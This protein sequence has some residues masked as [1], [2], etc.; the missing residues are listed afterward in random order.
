MR[1][2]FKFLYAL[3]V[4]L[5][6]SF[7][8]STHA[9]TVRSGDLLEAMNV[10]ADT[11]RYIQ[12]TNTIARDPDGQVISENTVSIGNGQYKIFTGYPFVRNGADWYETE[13]ATTTKRLYDD[14][15]RMTTPEQ[16]W[17]LDLWPTVSVALA[18]TF[19]PS[20]DGVVSKGGAAA[21]WNTVRQDTGTNAYP[22]I[23]SGT[24][25]YI[26]STGGNYTHI[27]RGIVCFDGST[28]NDTDIVSSG[29]LNFSTDDALHGGTPVAG[30]TI[31]EYT[32]DSAAL[33]TDDY[34]YAS[35]GT[36]SASDDVI[37]TTDP[38]HSPTVDTVG[39]TLNDTGKAVVSKTGTFCY[40]IRTSAD[41]NGYDP[42]ATTDADQRISL[43]WSE[44]TGTANDPSLTLTMVTPTPTPT[45]TA[46]PSPTPTG[47][48]TSTAGTALPGNDVSTTLWQIFA[49]S[50][51]L[52]I[53]WKLA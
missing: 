28:L 11:V 5:A 42:E 23:D 35:H 8:L 19:A 17:Y 34:A 49:I 41:L 40:S 50:I 2:A 27:L 12:R 10:D 13:T 38:A 26:A 47:T 20:I 37:L 9:A 33:T 39:W 29:G 21:S 24:V 18:Q 15:M 45:P 7:A 25:G 52:V 3:G 46:T 22:D 43:M 44:A 4:A 48:T 31:A 14:V 30:L 36:A 1:H 32:G 16:A 6:A 53:V 51:F